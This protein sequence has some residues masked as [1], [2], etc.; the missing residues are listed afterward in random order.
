MSVMGLET[1][2]GPR[3]NSISDGSSCSVSVFVPVASTASHREQEAVLLFEGN[4]L[5]VCVLYFLEV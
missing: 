4:V 1:Q 2:T 5:R 3:F